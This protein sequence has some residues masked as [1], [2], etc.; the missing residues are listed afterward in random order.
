MFDLEGARKEGYSDDEIADYLGQQ[1]SY[2]VSGARKEG[3]MPSEIINHLMASEQPKDGFLK[4]TGR[5]VLGAAQAVRGL[6]DPAGALVAQATGFGTAERGGGDTLGETL[7]GGTQYGVG[8]I[9]ESVGIGAEMI[10]KRLRDPK[11]MAKSI[12]Q[13]KG[14][15]WI[16]DSFGQLL[17]SMGEKIK[18]VAA[19]QQGRFKSPY[20]GRDLW[21]EPELAV[22][23]RWLARSVGETGPS[24][25]ASVLPGMGAAKGVQI[26]GKTLKWTPQLIDK[27]AKAGMMITGGAA[28]GGLEGTGTYKEALRLGMSEPEAFDAATKMGFASAALNAISLGK[29]FQGNPA[30][31][32]AWRKLVNWVTSGGTE[33]LTE[34]AE[35]PAEAVI[36]GQD[37]V[38]AMKRGVNV[39]PASFLLG[40]G[41]S[42]AA[43]MMGGEQAEAQPDI[44]FG[45]LGI[46]ETEAFTPTPPGSGADIT[47]ERTGEPPA[48]PIERRG[49]APVDT[50]GAV[51]GGPERRAVKP[52]APSEK[53]RAM[54]QSEQ[55]QESDT[56]G[57]FELR[58]GD[59]FTRAGQTFEVASIGRLGTVTFTNGQELA[60]GKTILVD[61]GSYKQKE[62]AEQP[63]EP[64]EEKAAPKKSEQAG[65]DLG[66]TGK[67]LRA[68]QREGRNVTIE[69]TELGQAT[70]EA[71]D[72]EAQGAFF[73]TAANIAKTVDETIHAK[74]SSVKLSSF[75]AGVL[76]Q[77]EQY[78]VNDT[79]TYPGQEKNTIQFDDPEAEARYQGAKGAGQRTILRRVN[80]WWSEVKQYAKHEPY[81]DKKKDAAVINIMR[82][83]ENTPEFSKH[84]AAEGTTGI[85]AGLGPKK[86]E[87]FTK[88]LVLDDMVKDLESGLLKEPEAGSGQTLP[89]GFKTIADVKR[90]QAR[91]KALAD[92]NKDIKAALEK[93]K[94]LNESLKRALV[95]E[96]LLSEEVLKDERY[97]HH[98]VLQYLDAKRIGAGSMDVRVHKKGYQRG[99]KGVSLDYNTEYVEAEFEWMAQ[100]IAQ[101]KTA[102][103][104]KMLQP[105][106]DITDALKA[107]AKKEGA[108]DFRT[109]IPDDHVIWK[110]KPGTAWFKAV[111][112]ND[113]ILEQVLAGER[114]L[115]EGDLRE[116]MA[117][118]RDAEWIVP[119]RVAKVLDGVKKLESGAI[120]DAARSILTTWKQ[121]TLLNPIRVLKYN[122]NNTSGD[123]DIAMAYDPK[124]LKYLPAAVRDAWAY[125]KGKAST[126][127]VRQAIEYGVINSGLTVQEIPDIGEAGLFKI[128]TG[129][130]G[131]LA[132]RYW[133][134]VKGLTNFREHSLRL[135]A[136]RYFKVELAKGK[137]MYAASDRNQ[138]DAEKDIDRKAALLARD[139]IGDYG[140]IS[141]GGQW[142]RERMIPFWSWMEI[143]APRYVRLFRNAAHEVG[144]NR[145]SVGGR[146]SFL[147]GKK[148][149]GKYAKH[150]VTATM[151]YTLIAL[152][153]EEAKR[154][155]DID[156][157]EV[158]GM[159]EER[160]QYY[161]ILGKRKDGTLITL[162]FE[163]A[164][165]DALDW[166]ALGNLPETLKN[167]YAGKQTI[168]E[169]AVDVIHEPINRI[170]NASHPFL[171]TFFETVTG[172]TLFPDISKPRPIRDR[173]EHFWKM[174]SLDIPY[175]YIAGKPVRGMEKDIAGMITYTSDPGERAY[176]NAR[177]LEY[178]F[179]DKEGQE[180]PGFVPNRKSNALY[181]FKQ[182]RRFKD[183]K[184]AKKYFMEY[185]RLGGTKKGLMTSLEKGR[186]GASIPKPL[187]GKFKSRL[188]KQQD[189]GFD[190]AQEWYQKHMALNA[191]DEQYIEKALQTLKEAR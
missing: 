177:K 2:D 51:Y 102:E 27:L 182:A 145:L 4:R 165:S 135:A 58:P 115:T 156:D 12:L 1:H 66:L 94:V 180:R 17:E 25:M 154:L 147:L 15:Q 9:K 190:Q 68:P 100:A 93:R 171:K 121:W 41:G 148:L 152:W 77:T 18:P 46:P 139:L 128:L 170:V 153:N 159:Y 92:A 107:Q 38:E 79:I 123:L 185:V 101:L 74:P 37:V 173:Q 142:L 14:G 149:A 40:M 16:S 191:S 67:D 3:Y 119:D 129:K 137:T 138:V 69:E 172:K 63:T 127:Q 122:L 76:P 126:P 163:G 166:F 90:N 65:L 188:S 162:R 85:L 87:V 125:Y 151:L 131:N 118:G 186:P 104:L 33:A 106:V 136:F 178:D 23:P 113:R 73:E 59:T 103:M 168:K 39:M 54:A 117:R 134:K 108:E 52:L 99:R 83:F 184:A 179:L 78:K 53:A 34:A 97:F 50:G 7:Y 28:G 5:E 91:F 164:L 183:E 81:L 175:R 20:E 10:G 181:Y 48:P 141:K 111:T 157:D 29:M 155:F 61:K 42:A 45:T 62:I 96:K 75:P 26:A 60:E 32:S 132:E 114:E 47:P 31:A 120:D 88:S 189:R 82:E 160:R 56:V 84:V 86:Y 167:I 24:I 13:G 110:P 95:E 112:V 161:I 11:G 124:I 80:D 140:N 72:R 174:L 35:E 133:D 8:G 43:S 130:E 105:T 44:D 116:V 158:E 57:A 30:K 22:D 187:R 49:Q 98:Q 55:G 89:F 70:K 143:N 169:T 6:T 109:L 64:K 71:K 144:S 150:A 36:L 176:W 19:A 146:A 21:K